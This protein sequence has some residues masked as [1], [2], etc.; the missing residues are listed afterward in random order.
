[1]QGTRAFV[2]IKLNKNLDISEFLCNF[3]TKIRTMNFEITEMSDFSGEM[4]HI[5]SVT[6]KG[7]SQTLLEQFF[8]E[9]R[10]YRE[11]LNIIAQKLMVMGNDTGCRYEFFK[12]HEGA[13]A[14]GVAALRV[15]QMRLYCLYFDKT[16][17]FF[18]SGGFKPPEIR[19]YQEDPTLY[20]KAQQMRDIAAKI[21]KA[22]IDK[23]I[24]IE[25]DGSLTI[26]FWDDE[27]D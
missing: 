13:L 21:N 22:I 5:Y 9:N 3:A 15:G 24:V 25:E 8:D 17:V 26:N 4:A 20:M 11:E 1:M 18:G 10:D 6:L 12:H 23:D 19:S 14:D 7:E 16:A 2:C 27:D